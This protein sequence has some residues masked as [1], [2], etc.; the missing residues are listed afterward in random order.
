MAEPF[1]LTAIPDL[2]PE[3]EFKGHLET[4]TFIA[5][6]GNTTHKWWSTNIGTYADD[7]AR[8]VPRPEARRILDQLRRGETV[9]FPGLWA[10]DEIKHKFGGVG[11]E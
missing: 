11:N 10:L 1:T 6:D 4:V 3:G 2:L 9:T 8:I 7:F 5:N